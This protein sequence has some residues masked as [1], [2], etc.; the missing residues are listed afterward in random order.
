MVDSQS[1]T[2]A[3]EMLYLSHSTI[4]H[5]LKSLEKELETTLIIRGNGQ[6]T[7]YLTPKGE[8]FV[9]IARKWAA[10]W[11]DTQQFKTDQVFS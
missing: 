9:Q 2:K 10:L 1:I 4:S 5:R 3:A 11:R 6:R 8:E 7:I